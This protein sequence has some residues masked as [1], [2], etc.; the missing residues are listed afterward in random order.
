M[1]TRIRDGAR[2]AKNGSSFERDGI[3]SKDKNGNPLVKWVWADKDGNMYPSSF[4]ANTTMGG[5]PYSKPGTWMMV[6]GKVEECRN[7]WHFTSRGNI[8]SWRPHPPSWYAYPP[9]WTRQLWEVQAAGVKGPSFD[10]K[11]VSRYLKFVRR[12]K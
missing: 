11:F 9:V 6:S 7:G 2:R 3:I 5:E 4:A 10:G 8:S 1:S 12:V